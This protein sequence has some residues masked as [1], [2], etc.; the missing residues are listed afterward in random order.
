MRRQ[1][2][3]E[4]PDKLVVKMWL[5]PYLTYFTMGVLV[6]LTVAMFFIGAFRPQILFTCIIVACIYIA[7]LIKQRKRLPGV[8]I[9]QQPVEA[10]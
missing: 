5:F 6:A 7:C 9:E 10:E 3:K 4:S 8:I 2:E 1:I